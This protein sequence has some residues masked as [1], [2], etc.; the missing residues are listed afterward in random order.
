MADRLIALFGIGL[1]VLVLLSLVWP[2]AGAHAL[3][4]YAAGGFLASGLTALVY[5]DKARVFFAARQPLHWANPFF[6]WR[7][8]NPFICLAGAGLAVAGVAI[9]AA[10]TSG[11]FAD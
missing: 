3:P 1:G 2:A 10:A 7:G 8:A 6:A 9:L 4:Y 11:R 5:P